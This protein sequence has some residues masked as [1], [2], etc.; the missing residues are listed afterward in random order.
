[1]KIH[2]VFH[3]ET[4]TRSAKGQACSAAWAGGNVDARRIHADLAARERCLLNQKAVPLCKRIPEDEDRQ[5]G[6]HADEGRVQGKSECLCAACFA[7][8]PRKPHAQ[9]T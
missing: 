6:D 1:M 8:A 3:V 5:C 9:I 2:T 7:S 4:T